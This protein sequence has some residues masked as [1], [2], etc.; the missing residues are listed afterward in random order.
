M[1]T[2]FLEGVGFREP[3]LRLAEP[4]SVEREGRRITVR[5]LVATAT[6]TDL[7][8]DFSEDVGC[9]IPWG[10]ALE[11]AEQVTIRAGDATVGAAHGRANTAVRVGRIERSLVLRPIPPEARRVEVVLS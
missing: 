1:R 6:A 9:C 5:Q 3:G 10:S 8:Y 11:R 7:V 2:A 4:V